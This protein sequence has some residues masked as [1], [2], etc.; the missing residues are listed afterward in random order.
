MQRKDFLK[1]GFGFLGMSLMVPSLLKADTQ[2]GN[3]CTTTQ[4]LMEGPFPTVNPANYLKQSIIGNRTGVPF[5]INI[6]IMNT[7]QSCKPLVNVLVDIWQ[8]DKD[9]YYSQYGGAGNP[10]QSKDMRKED[11]LR[12]RQITDATGKVSY[13]SIFPG[14]YE[15]RSTHIHVHV[16]ERGGKSLLISQIA[17]PEGAN[18]V[19]SIVNAATS[20][21]YTK[22]MNGYTYNAQDGVFNGNVG[23]I[24][25]T[26]TGDLQSGYVLSETMFVSGSAT[27]GTSEL[28]AQ[29]QFKLDKNF[30]NPFDDETTIPVSLLLPSEVKIDILDLQGRVV[31]IVANG[32]Y[33]HGIQKVNV[34]TNSLNLASGRYIYCVDVKNINGTFRQSGIMVKK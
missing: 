32:S 9:G 7:N 10:F 30:P 1:N 33:N 21:G 34:N 15:G 13:T 8:C 5:T 18:S 22:G 4:V 11:F 3:A 28:D 25:G 17:F 31:G 24:T 27:A 19:V 6:S 2:N 16:Y 23:D 29:T 26:I 12:G 14:W 20:Y